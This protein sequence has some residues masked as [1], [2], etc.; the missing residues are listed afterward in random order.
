MEGGG[1]PS[2]GEKD[3][4]VRE[5][6][7]K[8]PKALILDAS[9]I[10]HLRN[11]SILLEFV[12]AGYLVMTTSQVVEEVRD[13]GSQAVLEVIN[14]SVVNV[15][16]EP[17]ERMIRG[18]PWLSRADASILVLALKLRSKGYRVAVLTD[19]VGLIRS[20]KSVLRG[21]V[22]VVTVRVRLN[23]P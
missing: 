5:A 2:E 1:A 11:P 6:E 23:K 20:L 22:K 21:D 15:E 16:E 9:G 10:F 17:V 18:N 14:P 8:A 19:D 3:V 13:I 12:N 4:D 7:E